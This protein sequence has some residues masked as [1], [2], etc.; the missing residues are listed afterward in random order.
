MGYVVVRAAINH[1]SRYAYIEQRTDAKADTCARFL[2]RALRRFTDLGLEPAQTVLTDNARDYWSAK[3][4]LTPPYTPRC[5]ERP[6]GSS[7]R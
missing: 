4:I 1:H 2:A 5:M 7:R 3:H 6:K